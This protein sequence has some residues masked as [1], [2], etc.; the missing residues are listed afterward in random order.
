VIGADAAVAYAVQSGQLELNVMMPLMAWEVLFSIDLLA[1]YLPVLSE[2]C[3]RGIEADAERC[4]SYHAV[5]PALATVLNPLIG[6]EAAAAV[7]K[8][9]AATGEVVP[10]IVLRRRLLPAS[11]LRRIFS[12]ANLSGAATAR[13]R[14]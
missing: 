11:T 2:R 8:E 7:A 9:S 12:P 5:S 14:H 3:L 6:Y 1:N 13:R 4:A 10:E